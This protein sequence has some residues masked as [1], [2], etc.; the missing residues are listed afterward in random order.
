VSESSVSIPTCYWKLKPTDQWNRR[1][2]SDPV[3]HLH[4]CTLQHNTFQFL[5]KLS[6]FCC[7]LSVMTDDYP[8]GCCMIYMLRLKLPP[9]NFQLC[10]TTL[11]WY[12]VTNYCI[13]IIMSK[14]YH[15]LMTLHITCTRHAACVRFLGIF[16]PYYLNCNGKI[17]RQKWAQF[18]QLKSLHHFYG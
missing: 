6:L 18:I 5:L 14:W 16:P 4:N 15:N 10:D 9:L 13:S 8:E 17:S 12:I 11:G 7:S 3:V 1:T 2:P